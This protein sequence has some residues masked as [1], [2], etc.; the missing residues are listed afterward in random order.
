MLSGN[1]RVTLLNPDGTIFIDDVSEGDLWYF[2][3]AI[4][5]Q[6]RGSARW[7]VS[8]YSFS[9]R[10]CSRKDNTFPALG[11]AGTYAGEALSKNFG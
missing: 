5:I 7:F 3:A 2:P 10:A 6:S 8:F 9:M 1:A 4:R 11:V